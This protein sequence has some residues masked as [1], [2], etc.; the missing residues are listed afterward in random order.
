MTEETSLAFSFEDTTFTDFLP[1]GYEEQ[2]YTRWADFNI[3]DPGVTTYEA[4]QF[5]FQDLT[6]RFDLPIEVLLQGVR[7]NAF[8]SWSIHDLRALFAVTANDYRRVLSAMNN[9]INAAVFPCENPNVC[10]GQFTPKSLLTVEGVLRF[11]SYEAYLN[12]RA[13]VRYRGLGEYFNRKKG[14][15]HFLDSKNVKHV[16]VKIRVNYKYQKDKPRYRYKIICAIREYLL[17]RLNT[18]NFRYLKDSQML[19]ESEGFGTYS[20]ASSTHVVSEKAIQKPY[21][22]KYIPVSEIYTVLRELDFLESVE[23]V[24]IAMS[25]TGRYTDAVLDLHKYCF[26]QLNQTEINETTYINNISER[27]CEEE[28]ASLDSIDEFHYDATRYHNLGKFY[29]V[30]ESFP[31]NYGMAANLLDQTSSELD[32]SG[33]FR[34]YLYFMDQVR[35]NV[36]AQMGKYPRIFAVDRSLCD[37]Y[38][39]SLKDYPYYK[40]LTISGAVCDDTLEPKD[41]CR[42]MDIKDAFRESRLN[43]L[44]ALNGWS[45]DQQVPD[46]TESTTVLKVKRSFLDL[47]HNPDAIICEINKELNAIFRSRSLVL[48]QEM[49][50]T[51]LQSKV[52]AVR[53]LEHVF[54]QPVWDKEKQMDFALTIFLFPNDA[55]TEN[56]VTYLDFVMETIHDLIPVHI[57]FQIVWQTESIFHFDA[58]LNAAYPKDEIFYF[59]KELT[60]NQKRAMTWLKIQCDLGRYYE[61]EN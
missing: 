19:V 5:A 13:L 56:D 42:D 1:E 31:N 51:V 3:H 36:L 7:E 50:Y 52:G 9:V 58:V 33:N 20:E 61:I 60:K 55:Q 21:L 15:G 4:L 25:D 47:V 28:D 22:R 43:Y 12:D 23:S 53:I 59:D 39:H 44:L 37:I 2:L 30:Q 16:D 46:K 40:D 8:S 54:L 6:Y 48:F 17:P 11:T 32:A 26:T 18:F 35:A 10:E 29:S 49:I 34:G 24:E 38:S 57:L 41:N 14:D 27:F 45:A